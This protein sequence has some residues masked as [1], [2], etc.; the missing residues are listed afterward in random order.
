ML[1]LIQSHTG[2][3]TLLALFSVF[4]FIGTLIIVPWLVIRIPAD[5]FSHVKREKTLFA[6]HHPLIRII[7]LVIKNTL[8]YIVILL[9]IALLILPGQG[10]LTILAGLVLV[11]FPGKYKFERWLVSRK[12]VLKSINWLRRRAHKTPLFIDQ[13]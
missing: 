12:R 1:E 5:Y 11:D 2:L 8:G 10:I 13:E 4:T 6:Q 9:G 7:L 3:V